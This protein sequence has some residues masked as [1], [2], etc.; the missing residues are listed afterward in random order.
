V[1]SVISFVL[2][3]R[4]SFGNTKEMTKVPLYGMPLCYYFIVAAKK[5]SAIG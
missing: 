4:D 5:V 2:S 3:R 1:L